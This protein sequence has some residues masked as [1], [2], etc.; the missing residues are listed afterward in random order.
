MKADRP[1]T[2]STRVFTMFPSQPGGAGQDG[3]RFRGLITETVIG[4]VLGAAGGL[5][6]GVL[7]GLLWWVASG[8]AQAV[9]G[10]GWAGLWAAAAAGGVASFANM[11]F[12]WEPIGWEE[13][14]ANRRMTCEESAKGLPLSAAQE[15]DLIIRVTGEAMRVSTPAPNWARNDQADLRPPR[16]TRP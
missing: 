9:L 1:L 13:L 3:R 8:A 6:F 16:A 15:G 10:F 7:F 12:G 11:W 2:I 14:L 4:A 5:L